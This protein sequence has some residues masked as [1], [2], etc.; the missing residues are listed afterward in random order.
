MFMA[1]YDDR[2]WIDKGLAEAQ[3]ALRLDPLLA[4]THGTL[5]FGYARKGLDTEA[6]L[7]YL[8][9]LELNP[10][11]GGNNLSIHEATFG[12]FEESLHWARRAFALSGKQANDYYHVAVPLVSLRDDDLSRWW[13]TEGE[14]RSPTFPRVQLMLAVLE[15]LEGRSSNALERM[16]RALARSPDDEE[17]KIVLADVA[18]LADS[19]QLEAALEPL[20]KA[21]ASSSFALAETVRLRYA[22]V[23]NKK[24]EAARAAPHLAEAER[25]ALARI[26]QGD[27][28]PDLRVELAAVW[29]LRGDQDQALQWLSRG[30]E[31]GYRHFGLLERDPIL[32]PLRGD[33]RFGEI[34]DRMRRDVDAQ[35]QRARERGLLDLQQ[36][37]A[38]GK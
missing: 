23:L 8:R 1:Y 7:S 9:A 10:N 24:G 4:A 11:G 26:A 20:M 37:V 27:Q 38:S 36:L 2:S 5:A 31:A 3:A 13:L 28:T 34:I 35:R 30:Y 12:R 33:Q 18:F 32:A 16:S 17:L 22:H 29:A 15:A 19:D 14:R 25:T 21:S 6:R